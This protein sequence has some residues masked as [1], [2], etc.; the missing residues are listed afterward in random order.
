MG[1]GDD[2]L[3]GRDGEG[4]DVQDGRTGRTDGHKKYGQAFG[5]EGLPMIFLY[6]CV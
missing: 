3:Y 1:I 4:A 2:G 6:R 5:G